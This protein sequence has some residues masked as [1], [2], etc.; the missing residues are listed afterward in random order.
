LWNF[1]HN[2]GEKVRFPYLLC[3]SV[4][5]H[6]VLNAPR[7]KREQILGGQVREG[8]Q[9]SGKLR[10]NGV[11]GLGPQEE[12]RGENESGEEHEGHEEPR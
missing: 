11:E 12:Q 5:L 4:A 1:V 10:A 6:G 2:E 9:H 8:V 3:L 7:N